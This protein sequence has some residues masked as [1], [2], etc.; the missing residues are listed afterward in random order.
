MYVPGYLTNKLMPST[1]QAQTAKKNADADGDG[2]NSRD[3][4]A[5]ELRM[6]RED[7]EIY[8]DANIRKV[9]ITSFSWTIRS[10]DKT[11][12]DE[13]LIV[14]DN[15]K[16][17]INKLLSISWETPL[18]GILAAQL[19]W[20]LFGFWIPKYVKKWSA[21][22]L[23][24]NTNPELIEE[25][26][27]K[28]EKSKIFTSAR[29]NYILMT[30]GDVPGGSLRRLVL[31]RVIQAEMLRE[32]ANFNAMVKGIITAKMGDISDVS[33]LEAV[34]NAIASIEQRNYAIINDS[35]ELDF[36]ELVS[37][38][39]ATS[40]AEIIDRLDKRCAKVILGQSNTTELP[41]SGGSRAALTVQKMITAD[42]LLNDMLTCQSMI[43][44]Q[45]LKFYWIKN[46]NTPV[47]P[48]EFEIDWR[49]DIDPEKLMII[50]DTMLR[51]KIPLRSDEVYAAGGFTKPDNAVDVFEGGGDAMLS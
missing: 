40:F 24:W 30:D 36:K 46:Y 23:N 34:K 48:F 49:E 4:H 38:I 8:T 26:S 14:R 15:L 47:C 10:K 6:F 11:R 50:I 35:T 41:N 51:N 28:G 3:L 17:C 43:N 29:E 12:Q 25:F 13:A 5:I 44:D 18:F 33:E 27:I 45:L 32:W 16:S 31:N 37:S 7:E 22:D 9:G 39:G 19:E 1:E 42:I 21:D 20:E 2:R